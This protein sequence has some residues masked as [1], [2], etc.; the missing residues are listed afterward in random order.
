MGESRGLYRI[1]VIKTDGKK[2]LGRPRRRWEG[3]I[4]WVFRKWNVG[5]I[6]WIVLA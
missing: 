1:L 5:G 6:D 4:K 2:P 3:N